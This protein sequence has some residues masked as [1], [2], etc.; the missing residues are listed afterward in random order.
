MLVSVIPTLCGPLGWGYG[1]TAL[2]LSGW[3]LA[4]SMD[5]LLHTNDTAA[6]RLLHVSIVY[7]TVL[8][9]VLLIAA[10]I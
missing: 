8:L 7:L 1:V 4:A 2:A 3:Y 5:F 9:V 6:R 10:R